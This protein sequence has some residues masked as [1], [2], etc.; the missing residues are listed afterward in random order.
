MPGVRVHVLGTVQDGGCPHPGC[1]CSNCKAARRDARLRR[2]VV[3]IA[4]EGRT[5][6]TLLV[7][8]SPDFRDQ[9][10]ALADATGRPPPAIDEIVITHAHVGHY[11]GLAFLGK[12][13]MHAPAMPV[14]CT[15]SVARF[16]EGNRPWA[17]LV[18]REEI[19]LRTHAFLSPHRGEDTD[20]LGFE[21]VGPSRRLVY[22]SDADVFPPA[23]IERIREAD[24]AIV[25]GTFYDEKELPNR[26]MLAV[27]HPTVR[28]SLPRLTGGRGQVYFTH[29][30]HT[31]P[32]LDPKSPERSALPAGFHVLEEGAVFDL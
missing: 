26:D 16:L 1:S 32:L 25:D 2:R 31:N 4:V 15:P 29:M 28:G 5:G 13:A 7:D 19:D 22:V 8:A 23:I 9:L 10:D 18:E 3:S 24:I 14:Y 30:N 12:E 6:R 17:H 11:L 20:T 21:I 27:R